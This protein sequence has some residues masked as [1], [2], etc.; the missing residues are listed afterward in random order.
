MAENPQLQAMV[1]RPRPLSPHLQIYRWTP[2]MAASIVHR[3]TGVA[4]TAGMALLAWWLVA[5]ASG[6]ES[7][8]FF[9][10]IAG[11]IVGKVVLFGLVWSLAFHLL[12]GVRHL[13]WDVGYGFDKRVANTIGVLIFAGSILIAVAVFWLGLGAAP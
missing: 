3:A 12:A 9:S 4:L 5:A 6:Y 10:M 13:F 1:T 8:E 11:S 2:T 7:Y